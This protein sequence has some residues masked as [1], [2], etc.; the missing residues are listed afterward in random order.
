M[1]SHWGISEK[2]RGHV[3]LL[4]VRKFFCGMKF[5][6]HIMNIAKIVCTRK[7]HALQ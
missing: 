1:S 3:R 4:V 5:P 6:G 2:F 7:C